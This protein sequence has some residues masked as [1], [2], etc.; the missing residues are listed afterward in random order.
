METETWAYDEVPTRRYIVVQQSIHGLGV[1]VASLLG[2]GE[3]GSNHVDGVGRW[4]CGNNVQ[5]RS[6]ALCR[7][8]PKPDAQVEAALIEDVVNAFG[9]LPSHEKVVSRTSK[10]I[11]EIRR[12]SNSRLHPTKWI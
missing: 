9:S 8:E 5:W 10:N 2:E 12:S 1:K 11:L 6:R 3:P 7:L 4:T